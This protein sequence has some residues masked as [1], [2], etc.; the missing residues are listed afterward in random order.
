MTTKIC[1]KCGQEKD[2][3]HYSWSIKGIKRHAKCL[4]CRSEERIDYYNKHKEEELAYK[5]ERQKDRRDEARKYVW[6]YL[7]EHVC[8]DCGEYDPLVLT[9]DHVRGTKKMDISQMVNQG[10]SIDAIKKEISLCEIRCFNCHMRKE[11]KRRQTKY[12]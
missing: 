10:Y 6:E 2:I 7:S 3:S 4:S 8:Q 5:Y 11:K 9:F 12:W 1:S